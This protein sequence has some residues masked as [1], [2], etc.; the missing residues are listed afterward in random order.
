IRWEGPHVQAYEDLLREARAA[1]IR[2][3]IV[4]PPEG[5]EFR[6][7]YPPDV[8]AGLTAFLDQLRREFGVMAVDG[9]AWLPDEAFADGHDVTP[10]WAKPFTERLTRE[11]LVRALRRSEQSE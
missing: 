5:T 8:E 4:V 7:W 2:V 11:A 3:A 6:S 9:R 10:P 1:G